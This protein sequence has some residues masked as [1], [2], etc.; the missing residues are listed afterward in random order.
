MAGSFQIKTKK[1]S[2]HIT[3][4]ICSLPFLIQTSYSPDSS[5]T[6]GAGGSVS[7]SSTER[8]CLIR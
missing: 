6:P 8:P 3:E 7:A 2:L 1:G 4:V 5:F